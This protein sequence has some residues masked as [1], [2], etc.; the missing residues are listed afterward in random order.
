MPRGYFKRPAD[1]GARISEGKRPGATADKARVRK[2]YSEGTRL[3]EI[4]EVTGVSPSTIKGWIKDLPKHSTGFSL[5]PHGA[6]AARVARLTKR[7]GEAIRQE[8]EAKE[9]DPCVFCGES[10]FEQKGWLGSVFHHYEDGRVD[11]AHCG[12]NAIRRHAA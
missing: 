2:M 5:R 4:A 1:L 12:C 9:N 6:R 11:R 10:S 8:M 3:G 7:E